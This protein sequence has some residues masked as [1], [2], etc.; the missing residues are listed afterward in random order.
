VNSLGL[1][2][3]GHATEG[4]QAIIPWRSADGGNLPGQQIER[5]NRK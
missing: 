1:I 3:F 2:A 5:R 4:M